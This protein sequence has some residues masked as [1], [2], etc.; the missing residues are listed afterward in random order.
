[1][2]FALFAAVGY[3]VSYTIY[4]WSADRA[5]FS[6]IMF[7]GSLYCAMITAPFALKEKFNPEVLKAIALERSVWL[8]ASLFIYLSIKKIGVAA[9]S[10]FES[11]Y[12]F[13]VVLF[14]AI[15]Y[16]EKPPVS[17]LIGGIFIFTGIAIIAYN[18]K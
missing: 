13:F 3:A 5:S 16:K 18:K 6:Y 7:F 2:E 14:V 4:S 8:V 10:T 9:T 1:M 17:L 15:I 11:V 12:P